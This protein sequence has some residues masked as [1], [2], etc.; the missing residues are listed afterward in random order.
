MDMVYKHIS[1]VT[2][3]STE[4]VALGA[5]D[6]S[7]NLSSIGGVPI[8]IVELPADVTPTAETKCMFTL[9]G[10]INNLVSKIGK[11]LWAKVAEGEGTVTYFNNSLDGFE[12]ITEL[13]A[14]VIGLNKEVIKLTTRATKLELDNNS[15]KSRLSSVEKAVASIQGIVGNVIADLVDVRVSNTITELNLRN[16]MQSKLDKFQVT[17]LNRI[18]TYFNEYAT[19]VSSLDNIV[20]VLTLAMNNMLNASSVNMLNMHRTSLIGDYGHDEGLVSIIETIYTT[21]LSVMNNTSKQTNDM[22]YIESV[23]ASMQGILALT[24][25]DL[26]DVK[27]EN[28][29]TK[30]DFA[31]YVK[32]NINLYQ[33]Q[34]MDSLENYL[35][36]YTSDIATFTETTDR[37]VLYW[38]SMVRISESTTE[39]EVNTVYDEII[40]HPNFDPIITPVITVL[41]DMMTFIIQSNTVNAAQDEQIDGIEDYIDNPVVGA[42]L[43]STGL[44]NLLGTPEES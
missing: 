2:I 41:R 10:L 5:S 17:V 40:S 1:T 39:E 31:T 38:D 15:N 29:L 16:E 22:E 44:F 34:M 6:I 23:I 21:S 20:T 43:D 13:R 19:E 9:G 8:Q 28:G 37:I 26:A 14:S 33:S 12:P 25:A 7:W 35:E 42:G 27:V 32:E 18:R 24:V 30:L 36:Q 11:Q 3:S 4:W